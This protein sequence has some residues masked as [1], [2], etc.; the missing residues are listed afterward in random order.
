MP[1][2]NI[3]SLLFFDSL[4]KVMAKQSGIELNSLG[5]NLFKRKPR[6]K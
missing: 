3:N 4:N 6:F 1:V 2:S 5:N